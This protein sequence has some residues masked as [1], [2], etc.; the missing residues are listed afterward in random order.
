MG[1]RKASKGK[2]GGIRKE[3]LKGRGRGVEISVEDVVKGRCRQAEIKDVE[4]G[5]GNETRERERDEEER[6]NG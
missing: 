1:C 2:A 6:E 4:G 3:L 5:L